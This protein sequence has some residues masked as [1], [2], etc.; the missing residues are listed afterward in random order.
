MASRGRH[1]NALVSLKME[2]VLC[3][4][5]TLMPTKDESASPIWFFIYLDESEASA[6]RI[7]KV[8][9]SAVYACNSLRFSHTSRN[10]CSHRSLCALTVDAA[11]QQKVA[12]S[13]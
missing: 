10:M 2:G 1:G 11:P 12:V 6:I 5:L 13:D 4:K 8:Q 3:G 9:R 7:M